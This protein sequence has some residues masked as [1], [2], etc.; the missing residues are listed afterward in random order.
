MDFFNSISNALN[1]NTN[2]LTNDL[3]VVSNALDPTKNGVSNA[4]DPTKNGVSNALDPTKNGLVSSIVNDTDINKIMAL[5]GA[6]ILGEY[7]SDYIAGR[8]LSILS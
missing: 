1:P 6:D 8:P 3:N 7:A 5:I 4:L 2:G